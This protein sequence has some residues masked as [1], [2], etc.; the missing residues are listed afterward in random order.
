MFFQKTMPIELHLIRANDFVRMDADEQL[1]FEESKQALQ[2]L[3]L[4]CRK[5]GL[6]RAMLDLRDLPVPEKP[7]FTMA[8]L[9]ALVKAFCDAGF[10]RQQHLAVLYDHDI[11]RG[12]RNFTFFSRLPGIQVQAFNDFESAITWLRRDPGKSPELQRGAPV[13][14]RKT[15]HAKTPG[16]AH[17]RPSRQPLRPTRKG[18]L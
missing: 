1:D 10:T 18:H 15:G 11:H 14:I 5:R 9:A 2:G 4:A 17:I 8:E 12:I 6:D 16:N 7:K 3:A 13:P